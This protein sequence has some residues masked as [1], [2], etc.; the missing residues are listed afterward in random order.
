MKNR[1]RGLWMLAGMVV[2]MGICFVAD[3]MLIDDKNTSV[4]SLLLFHSGM[5]KQCTCFHVFSVG[6]ACDWFYLILPIMIAVPTVVYICDENTTGFDRQIVARIGKRRF[7]RK[8][9]FTVLISAVVVTLG[10]LLLFGMFCGMVFPMEADYGNIVVIGME[11]DYMILLCDILQDVAR[12]LVYVG[13]LAIVSY[14]ITCISSN[15]YVVI[16]SVFLMNYLFYDKIR[17]ETFVLLL[18]MILL[19]MLAAR[20]FKERWKQV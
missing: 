17:M 3:V 10:A 1:V 4:L 11:K 14:I 6:M 16:T 9:L 7:F 20:L 19:Y 8:S 12:L 18:A 13:I 2:L 5:I 15:K